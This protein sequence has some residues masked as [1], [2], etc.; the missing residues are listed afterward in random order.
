MIIN[1]KVEI[2]QELIDFKGIQRNDRSSVSNNERIKKNNEF[3]NQFEKEL[4]KSISRKKK[5]I[6]RHDQNQIQTDRSIK[7]N[8]PPKQREAIKE[9]RSVRKDRIDEKITREVKSDKGEKIDSDK[10]TENKSLSAQEKQGT[11]ASEESQKK[12]AMKVIF[13]IGKENVPEKTQNKSTQSI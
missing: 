10:I 3:K 9:N 12:E 11:I 1:Q 5:I 4:K 2:R 6:E 8:K 13:N 7:S